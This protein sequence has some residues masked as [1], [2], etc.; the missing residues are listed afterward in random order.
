MFSPEARRGT[1]PVDSPREVTFEIRDKYNNPVRGEAVFFAEGAGFD[2]TLVANRLRTDAEGRV[3]VLYEAPDEAGIDDTVQVSFE[4]PPSAGSFDPSDPENLEFTVTTVDRQVPT[5]DG[6]ETTVDVA[7][8][9]CFDLDTLSNK[10]EFE[11]DWTA[12]IDGTSNFL[13]TVRLG[14]VDADNNE[15]VDSTEYRFGTTRSASE[16]TMLRDRRETADSCNGAY[17]AIITATS[18][19]GRQDRS[20]DNVTVSNP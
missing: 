15:L 5:G 8:G 9:D 16:N 20:S 10:Q 11:I 1:A 3:S 19:G 7:E 4:A 14:V 13:E 17:R 12:N 2:G 18:D 6:V